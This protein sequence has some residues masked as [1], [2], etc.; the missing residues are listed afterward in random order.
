MDVLA[1]DSQLLQRA[2]KECW[3]V[4]QPGGV[5]V[6]ASASAD[7][8]E[9]VQ[10]NIDQVRGFWRRDFPCQLGELK[11]MVATLSPLKRLTLTYRFESGSAALDAQ[12]RS[13][14]EQLATAIESGMFDGRRMVFV[15]FSDGEG[16]AD[17]N[18]RI[19]LRR[20]ES[21]LRAVVA[22][23]E[24]ANFEQLTLEAET[25]GE[26]MPMACDDSEWGR[27][28]NRRVEVWVR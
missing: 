17:G 15:G 22:A 5:F 19:A 1:L 28:I 8:G 23:A 26:A 20:A 14:I 21:V 13:N 3:R 10:N 27:Q 12:S 4:L 7:L 6:L 18:R 24:T 2:I 11:R 25:F 16:P 9:V